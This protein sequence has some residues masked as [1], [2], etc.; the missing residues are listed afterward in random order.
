MQNELKEKSK[1]AADFALW[2][3]EI[4]NKIHATVEGDA[5]Y[6]EALI[7]TTVGKRPIREWPSYVREERAKVWGVKRRLE[8]LGRAALLTTSLGRMRQISKCVDDICQGKD[9]G[10]EAYILAM[11]TADTLTQP[12][13]TAQGKGSR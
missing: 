8:R 3:T 11:V 5:L 6:L 7:E 10:G 13:T 9:T 1:N 2:R 12:A 4:V